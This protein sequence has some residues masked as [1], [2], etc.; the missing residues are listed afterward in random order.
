M[1]AVR[2]KR[3]EDR[4]T[5]FFSLMDQDK[6]GLLTY[7]EIYTICREAFSKLTTAKDEEYLVMMAKILAN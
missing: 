7:S 1:N 4:L 2:S 3:L 5:L 6:N